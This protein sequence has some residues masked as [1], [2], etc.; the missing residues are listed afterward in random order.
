MLTAVQLDQLVASVR[1]SIIG[2]YVKKDRTAD[3]VAVRK[4]HFVSSDS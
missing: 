1:L 4:L 2:A 3:L